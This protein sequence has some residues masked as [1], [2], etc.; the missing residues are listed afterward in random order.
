MFR[1]RGPGFNA[2]LMPPVSA[3]DESRQYPI[4]DTANWERIVANIGAIVDGLERTF[5][6]E[7]EKAVGRAPEWFEPGR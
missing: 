4:G 5:V 2:T 1:V 6:A 7:I 3:R